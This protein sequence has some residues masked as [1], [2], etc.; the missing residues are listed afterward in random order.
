MQDDVKQD[1]L[2]SEEVAQFVQRNWEYYRSK[3]S[4]AVSKAGS[5]EAL[6]KKDRTSWNWAGF[7]FTWAWLLYRKMYLFG[8]V[9][10]AGTAFMVF[11]EPLVGT[12]L[13]SASLAISGIVGAY[14]N[15]WYLRHTYK[16]VT[17]IRATVSDMDARRVLLGGA[18]GTNLP[19]AVATPI[20][21]VAVAAVVVLGP[22]EFGLPSINEL[23]GA[24]SSSEATAQPHY[25]EE[26]QEVSAWWQGNDERIGVLITREQMGLYFQGKMDISDRG[27]ISGTSDQFK[28][29]RVV[30]SDPDNDGW[31][32]ELVDLPG[33]IWTIRKRWNEAHDRFTITLFDPIG[34][35]FDL[36]F[37]R[38]FTP[39]EISS[40]TSN[41]FSG[42][43]SADKTNKGAEPQSLP[44]WDDSLR[45]LTHV[46]DAD[47][48]QLKLLFQ[49]TS[50]AMEISGE[51][52]SL[53]LQQV[54]PID[55]LVKF[56]LDGND[57]AVWTLARIWNEQKDQFYLLLIVPSGEQTRLRPVRELTDPERDAMAPGR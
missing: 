5:L 50:M 32:F 55:D 17:S 46:W 38:R 40:L 30:Q 56:T 19:A 31:S 21:V 8:G 42:T 22:S 14:G 11:S 4:K 18:G 28:P 37:I 9:V 43:A 33:D 25:S 27:L 2:S 49:P 44:G 6:I 24:S 48:E 15:S 29:F 36:N 26:L 34:R 12:D 7:L 3:W 52:H 45:D 47:G 39:D 23:S 35:K 13:S 10:A 53:N 54:N 20:A 41:Q 51:I 1:F 16:H 57:S